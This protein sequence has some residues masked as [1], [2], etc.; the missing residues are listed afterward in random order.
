MPVTMFRYVY[1]SLMLALPIEDLR[2]TLLAVRR[3]GLGDIYNT[4]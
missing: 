3:P 2:E 1:D 4:A